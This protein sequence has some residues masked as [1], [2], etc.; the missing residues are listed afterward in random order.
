M[1][2]TRETEPVF[3]PEET[4]EMQAAIERAMN[5]VRDP[6]RM[7]EACERMDRTREQI[8]RRIGLVDFAV[9]TIRALRDGDDE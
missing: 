9:P 7:R 2:T 6:R 3:T 1:S 4:A 8:R 5:G